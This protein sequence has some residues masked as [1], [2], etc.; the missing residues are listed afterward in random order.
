MPWERCGCVLGGIAPASEGG[1]ESP[2]PWERPGARAPSARLRPG[3]P[4]VG[5]SPAEPTSVSPGVRGVSQLSSVNKSNQR[6]CHGHEGRTGCS[7]GSLDFC[8]D[9]GV[10]LRVFRNRAILR[11]TPSGPRG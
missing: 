9:N 8:L 6:K 11:Y 1:E 2:W 10:H 3:Y 4:L 7:E 5:C